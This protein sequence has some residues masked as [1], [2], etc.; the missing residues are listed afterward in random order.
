MPPTLKGDLWLL[1]HC[2]ATLNYMGGTVYCKACIS[3][4][5]LTLGTALRGLLRK[6]KGDEEALELP[7]RGLRL[8]LAP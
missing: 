7:A 4:L 5:S 1:F 2:E 3:E 8:P 6:K